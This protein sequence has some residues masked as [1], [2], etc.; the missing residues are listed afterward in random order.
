IGPADELRRLGIGVVEDRP[1]VGQNLQDHP[2]VGVR[3]ASREPVSLLGAEALGQVAN[4]LIRRTG[5]LSSNVAEA[6]LFAHTRGDVIPDLQ[7]HVA[8]SLFYEHGFQQPQTHGFSLGPTLVSPLSRGS[9]ALRSAKPTEHPRID[10]RYFSEPEDLAALVA[11]VR[12]AREIV[13]QKAYSPFRGQALDAMADAQTDTEIERVIRH[14]AE[15]LYH[16]VGT[17]RMGPDADSV[18]DLSLRVRGVDGLR[19]A[20]ASIMP[21]IVNGNTHAPATMIAERAADLIRGL[22]QAPGEAHAAPEV[23]G[24]GV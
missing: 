19:V 17:C 20:D 8:P 14:S 10:P 13:A 18:V 23:Y 6:G 21:T 4:Y 1:E 2:I 24:V 7:F 12:M 16:P 15:T 5:M 22:A 9:L 11:G 3:W